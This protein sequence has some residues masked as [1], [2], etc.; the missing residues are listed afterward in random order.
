MSSK[1][2]WKITRNYS[3]SCLAF[4]KRKSNFLVKAKK[5]NCI[6]RRILTTIILTL[7]IGSNVDIL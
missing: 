6:C 1:V 5:K 7:K 2:Y 4:L 3:C